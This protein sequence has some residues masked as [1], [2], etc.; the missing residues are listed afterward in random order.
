MDRTLFY[1]SIVWL[2]TCD[3]IKKKSFFHQ[4]LSYPSCHP[5][6]VTH[7]RVQCHWRWQCHFPL[8]AS[9]CELDKSVIAKQCNRM[10]AAAEIVISHLVDHFFSGNQEGA[11][12]FS[13]WSICAHLTWFTR[14][15]GNYLAMRHTRRTWSIAVSQLALK[16]VVDN[17]VEDLLY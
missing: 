7:D 9:F 1:K 4:K 16:S 2:F 15:L 10:I 13:L 3:I 14:C 17:Y 8:F 12:N 6:Y 5:I 11:C